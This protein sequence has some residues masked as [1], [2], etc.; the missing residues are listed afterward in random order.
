M[1]ILPLWH[2]KSLE[3]YVL[4]LLLRPD[5]A[6]QVEEPSPCLFLRLELGNFPWDSPSRK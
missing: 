2:I 5:K 6:A 3:G 1:V 4:P